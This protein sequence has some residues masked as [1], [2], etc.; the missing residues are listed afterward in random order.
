MGNSQFFLRTWLYSA[1]IGNEAPVKHRSAILRNCLLPKVNR[2]ETKQKEVPLLSCGLH[3]GTYPSG[4]GTGLKW[5]PD[6]HDKT[7]FLMITP[8]WYPLTLAWTACQF[9]R[10]RTR[11]LWQASWK[12]LIVAS[13]EEFAEGSP[14][15]QQKGS[16]KHVWQEVSSLTSD[17][18]LPSY[19]KWKTGTETSSATV[20]KDSFT[21]K[22]IQPTGGWTRYK[23]PWK[24]RINKSD[25]SRIT[26]PRYLVAIEMHNPL[27]QEHHKAPKI[28]VQ[29]NQYHH[30]SILNPWHGL[31]G[32]T[33]LLSF[34]EYNCQSE[35]HYHSS[36]TLS[37]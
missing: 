15:I 27:W 14:G 9:G 24:C 1:L 11:R 18:Q 2:G 7:S 16:S 3:Q 12:W 6:M 8:G 25:L 19:F 33:S 34:F 22:S 37:S 13:T 23:E 5:W 32:R 26:S 17:C 36:G 35:K 21:A 28:E 4:S 29:Q 10:S 31:Q 30:L 20:G